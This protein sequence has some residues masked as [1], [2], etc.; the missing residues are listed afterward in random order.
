MMMSS[1]YISPRFWLLDELFEW[2]K[3]KEI[4]WIMLA[5]SHEWLRKSPLEYHYLG[6][7]NSS[8]N[9]RIGR[10]SCISQLITYHRSNRYSVRTAVNKRHY[11]TGIT[12]SEAMHVP[13][14]KLIKICH[15]QNL[16]L[17][18]TIVIDLTSS[19]LNHSLDKNRLL[20]LCFWLSTLLLHPLKVCV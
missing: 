1:F 20:N 3:D 15:V 18:L 4:W 11:E 16:I 14:F 13:C 6:F 10:S 8:L 12:C 5:E 19:R 7:Q 17:L 9:N 2:I